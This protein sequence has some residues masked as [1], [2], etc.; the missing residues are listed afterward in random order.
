[1][2]KLKLRYHPDRLHQILDRLPLTE[3]SD[4]STNVMQILNGLVDVANGSEKDVMEGLRTIK[5]KCGQLLSAPKTGSGRPFIS[6][7]G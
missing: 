2:K 5:L 7:I 1:M 4:L 3:E 6:V